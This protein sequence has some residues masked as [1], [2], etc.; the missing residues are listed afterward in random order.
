MLVYCLGVFI[1]RHSEASTGLPIKCNQSRW[2][3]AIAKGI[4]VWVKVYL[5]YTS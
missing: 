4:W 1:S 5:I 2:K 3:N